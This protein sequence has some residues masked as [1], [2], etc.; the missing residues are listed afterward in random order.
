MEQILLIVMKLLLLNSLFHYGHAKVIFRSVLSVSPSWLSPGSSVTLRCEVEHLP[1]GWRFY[2][3]KAVPDLLHN[4][5][6][7]KLLPGSTYGTTHNYYIIQSQ[8]HTAG[9]VCRAGRKGNSLKFYATNYSQPKFVWSTVS[10]PAASL[11][12]SPDR[13]QHF[14]VD[15]IS[16]ICGGSSAE[17]RVMRFTRGQRL[18]D[19]SSWGTMTGSTCTIENL[20]YQS[21]VYWCESGSGDFSNGVILSIKYKPR[22]VLSVSPSWLSPGSSVTL[23]CEIKPPSAGWRFYWYKAVPDL[24]SNSY[25]YDLLPGSTAGTEHDSYIIHGQTHTARYVCR[26]GRGDPEYHTDYSEPKFL[27]SAAWPSSRSTSGTSSAYG[28]AWGSSYI[29]H[30][31]PAA[32]LALALLT[33]TWSSH[34]LGSFPLKSSVDAGE[35]IRDLQVPS[36]HPAASLTVSPDREQHFTVDDISL[37]CGGSSAEWRVM[38]F[39][40]GGFLSDCASWGTMTGSTC[41]LNSRW[42]QR[43]VYW[44]ESGSGEFSNAVNITRERPV[45]SVSPS[46]LSPGSSVTLRCEVEDPSAGWRFYWYKAVPDLLHKNYSYDLLAGTGNGTAQ[47]FY[48]IHGQ[49]HTT[50]YVCRAGRGD[51]EYHTDYSDLKLMWSGNFHPAVSLTVSP[52]RS[53]HFTSEAVSLNCEGNSTGW[54]VM[55][56]TEAGRL[57]YLGNCSNLETRN[58]SSCTFSSEKYH[59]AVCWCEFRSG[60]FSNAFNITVQDTD[61][62]LVSPVHP[63]TEGASVSLSCRLREQ[64]TLSN[65]SFYHNDKLLQHDGREELNIS[66]VSKSDEGFYKCQ[67]AGKT[68][69]QSWMSVTAVS[70]PGS[71][72]LPV[73]LIFGPVGG[74]VCIF[75][76]LLCLSRQS[77]DSCWIRS[78]QSESSS[79]TENHGVNQ[80]ETKE[81]S[82]PL[83]AE[84]DIYEPIM[85]S[86]DTDADESRDVIYSVIGLKHCGKNRGLEEAE[87]DP[88]Y[89]NVKTANTGGS[90][91]PATAVYSEVRFQ[92]I[93]YNDAAIQG[94]ITEHTPGE[95]M[96]TDW[97]TPS[98]TH[99]TGNIFQKQT[100]LVSVLDVR[101][102]CNSFCVLLPFLLNTL[103]HSEPVQCER[104]RHL[105]VSSSWLTSGSSVT[106][107]C[108]IPSNGWRVYWYKAVHI[109]SNNSYHYE[110][111]PGTTSGTAE[112]SYVIHGQTHTA[113]YICKAEKRNQLLQSK[114]RFVWCVDSPPA[115]ASIKV[116]PDSVQHF[117]GETVSL[118]CE[119]RS[120]EWRVMRLTHAGHVGN[121][122]AWGNM[123]GSTCTVQKSTKKTAVY[124]CESG[125]DFSNAVNITV[126][127]QNIKLMSPV[128]PVTEGEAVTLVCNLRNETVFKHSSVSFY[129]ND[130]LIQN[131]TRREVNISAVSKTHEGFYK[132]ECSGEASPSS[133]ISVKSAS[134]DK[135]LLFSVQ[136]II[137]LILGILLIIALLLIL[138]LLLHYYRQSQDESLLY[139]QVDFCKKSK[140]SIDKGQ[141]SHAAEEETIYSEVKL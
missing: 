106:L 97:L 36:S 77:K 10:H 46:W 83:N 64:N 72:S 20:W 53:Q 131:D 52:D 121:C 141:A 67:H 135:N 92:T 13:E 132:C 33:T 94:A 124:W 79:Q 101:M 27:W 116:T 9:Y 119:G 44:C 49:T 25:S 47:Y 87:E 41:S 23:R 105:N 69:Q 6:S 85:Q 22:P 90:C 133:W 38:R 103:L 98:F 76:L 108:I 111:L 139:A 127:R 3:Y 55:E 26:A 30:W 50:G 122:S 75:L 45:L 42:Y 21:G 56:F 107:T 80:T 114:P 4:G 136:S 70:R 31:A 15:D 120:S 39:T 129:H 65:V 88:V 16:L 43:G 62:I 54:R 51:P 130:Q 2:W 100:G 117:S 59:S 126:Q 99:K 48:I 82:F 93:V 18:S 128:Q 73:L 34:Q 58:G 134:K 63:V 35:S 96:H 14:T 102:G 78:I 86:G 137:G 123:T 28:V 71:S 19:C 89:I 95:E 118:Q 60:E 110:E 7:C 74:I 11:T 37:I 81:D 138:V 40:G 104:R 140:S 17:W 1:A 24:L 5:Y 57:S 109:Q 125:S 66:A 61:V 84:V 8:T 112:D 115:S 12:V 68:S 91:F 113:G 32:D 29:L